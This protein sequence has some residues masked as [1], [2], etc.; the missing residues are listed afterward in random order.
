MLDHAIRYIR[1]AGQL[2]VLTGAGCSVDSGVP[3]FRSPT[4]WWRKLDPRK[5]A[6]VE[7]LETD[8]ELFHAFYSARVNLLKQIFPHKGHHVL[9]KWE[10]QGRIDLIATQN[11]DGLHQAAGNRKIQELH[12]SIR[13]FHCYKCGKEAAEEDFLNMKACSCGGKLRPGVVLFGESLPEQAWNRSLRAIE[14]ADAILVVGTSLQVYPANQLPYMTKGKLILI[15]A[16]ETGQ[17][18]RFDCFLQG[19]AADIMV[20]L[21]GQI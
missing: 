3:D 18:D 4:G 21:D 7:A 9:W 13:R 11:V 1:A 16:E 12:G 14:A 2:V 10:Q 17:E 6:T 19:R 8:Y 15:N 5:V 20:Q